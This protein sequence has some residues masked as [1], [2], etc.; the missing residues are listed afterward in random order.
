VSTPDSTHRGT[1]VVATRDRAS[2]LPRTLERLTA[3][4]DGWPVVV[5]DDASRDDTAAV[6]AERFPGVQ[7]IRLDESLG[8]GAR[9]VGAEAARTDLVAFA[10]DDSWYAP[11]SLEK[12]SRSFES[13]PDLALVAGRC[14]VEP[15]GCVDPVSVAQ[16]SSPLP[17]SP[18][19]PS[20][21]GF[22]AC[23]AVVRRQAFS[24]V[25]GFHPVIGFAGEE[26]VLAMDLRAAGWRL[27]HVPQV[28]VH[29]EPGLAATGRPGR[30][31]LQLRNS[32]LSLWLRRPLSVAL[33]ATARLASAAATD[34]D[35]RRALAG[36]ARRMPAALAD[37]R[38]VPADVEA[39]LRTLE[40]IPS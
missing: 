1:I 37:R 17:S 7:L 21:L 5:V 11:G 30:R 28:L 8:A 36:V 38:P 34:R 19:G 20:V 16:E 26:E 29:H 24:E 22:L 9:N 40:E 18:P 4:P 2:L 3:L 10:D 33:A 32:V 12:A 13:H 14:L 35:S 15:D 39:D 6:V 31:A 27:V 23:T 25:G